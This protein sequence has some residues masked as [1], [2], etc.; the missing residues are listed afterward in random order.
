ME[1]DVTR[2]EDLTVKS[3]TVNTLS[4]EI[5]ISDDNIV[6]TQDSVEMGMDQQLND[7]VMIE[8]A[9]QDVLASVNDVDKEA[10]HIQE[11][12]RSERLKKDA[13]L[14]TME[15]IRRVAQKKNLEGLFLEMDKEALEAG[16]NT[17]LQIAAKLLVKKMRNDGRQT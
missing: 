7:A 13:N 14:T 17:L 15:K 5:F 10:Q 9:K 3:T 8:A 12:R 4:P 1:V 16:V 2:S 11:R 6:N